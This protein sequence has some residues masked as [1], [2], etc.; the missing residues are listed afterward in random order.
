MST[1]AFRRSPPVITPRRTDQERP[2]NEVTTTVIEVFADVTCPFTHVE[3]RRFVERREELGR[4]DVILL[5]RAWP[6]EIVNGHPLDG[7]HI[8][9]VIQ[10]IRQQVDPS[11]FAGFVEASFPR[12]SLGALALAAAAYE[13]DL[14]L[15]ERVSLA[16]RDLVFEH[17]VD[18]AD[19]EV[20]SRLAADHGLAP[21]LADERRVLDDHADGVCR[22]VIG[23]PHYFTPAGDFFCPALDV[24][25]DATSQL[26]IAPATERFDR[27]V[28]ACFG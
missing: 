26:Q 27:F 28:T 5:V 14:G 22:G 17:G 3:L 4:D 15:G 8:A 10:A 1:E 16:L 18:I 6:L 20:L 2:S 7:H 19:H 13:Q 21:D 25:R 12:S 24:R 9:G 11:L 23:S